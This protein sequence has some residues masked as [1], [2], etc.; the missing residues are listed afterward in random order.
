MFHI[1]MSVAMSVA[2]SKI[3]VILLQTY[4]KGVSGRMIV[5][6]KDSWNEYMEKLANEENEWEEG[7]HNVK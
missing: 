1:T 5:G 3:G 4:L 2:L 7:H 6:I